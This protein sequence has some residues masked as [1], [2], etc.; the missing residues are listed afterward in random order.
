MAT[1]E[2]ISAF[3]DA[4]GGNEKLPILLFTAFSDCVDSIR[5]D[6]KREYQLERIV[7]QAKRTEPFIPFSRFLV[8]CIDCKRNAADFYRNGQGALT[9]CQQQVA[10]KP[11]ALHGAING[12]TPKAKDWH[13]ISAKLTCQCRRYAGELDGTGA[14]RVKAQHAC[15]LRRQYCDKGLRA[16]GF[17]VLPCISIKIFV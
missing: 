16:A 12:E 13:I 8:L 3:A 15:R 5:D 2:G 11:L 4:T 7:Q 14:D 9:R 10:T 17:V 6:A 1:P